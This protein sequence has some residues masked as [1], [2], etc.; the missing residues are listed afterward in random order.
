MWLVVLILQTASLRHMNKFTLEK[1]FASGINGHEIMPHFANVLAVIAATEGGEENLCDVL[2]GF[3]VKHI[4]AS[5]GFRLFCAFLAHG[6]P[7]TAY[8]KEKIFCYWAD[9]QE[10]YADFLREYGIDLKSG[11][12]L[13][14]HKFAV[15]LSQL[16]DESRFKR[17]IALRTLDLSKYK[18][19]DYA[20]MQREQEAAALPV[21]MSED[22]KVYLDNVLAKL[23]VNGN[24]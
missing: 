19:P 7:D 15:L 12:F 10:I 13:H 14:W 4:E 8:A 17:K 9:A 11:E 16:S 1:G 18:G 21:K 23:G 22:E 6:Q 2:S 3:F 24:G 20:E 5:E